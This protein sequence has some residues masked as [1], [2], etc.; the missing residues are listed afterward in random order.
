MNSVSQPAHLSF[1]QQKPLPVRGLALAIAVHLALLGFLWVGVSWQNQASTA[2]EAEVWDLTTRE[3]APLP[4]PPAPEPEPEPQ[5]V[6][7]APA[8]PVEAPRE[9]P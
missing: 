4:T 3:A 7:K 9:D 6:V 1:Q 2:V 5:P 8:P